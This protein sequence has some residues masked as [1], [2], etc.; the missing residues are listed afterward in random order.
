M[1]F[2]GLDRNA[3]Q[4]TSFDWDAK[5]VWYH[6]LVVFVVCSSVSMKTSWD[7]SSSIVYYIVSALCLHAISLPDLVSVTECCYGFDE[8]SAL[9]FLMACNLYH[10]I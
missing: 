9:Y 10:T 7:W 6:C 8:V 1:G 4:F 5:L 3:V 2:G